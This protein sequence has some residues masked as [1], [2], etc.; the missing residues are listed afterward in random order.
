[1]VNSKALGLIQMHMVFRFWGAWFLAAVC[2]SAAVAD[3]AIIPPQPLREFR[4]V[5]VATVANI[6][7]PSKKGLTTAEQKA[8][9]LALLDRA[10]QLRLNAVIFQVRPA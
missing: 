3:P 7:W 6:D 4:G 8:E 1:R 9:L 5:W 2:W 10:A